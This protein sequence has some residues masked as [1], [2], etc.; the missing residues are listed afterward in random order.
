MNELENLVYRNGVWYDKRSSTQ[1]FIKHPTNGE[2]IK[3]PTSNDNPSS[4]VITPPEAE[5]VPE[6][7]KL[8]VKPIVRRQRK[9][10]V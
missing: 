4:G 1:V 7:L 10:K 9:P 5:S 8:D 2:A 3:T 6:G